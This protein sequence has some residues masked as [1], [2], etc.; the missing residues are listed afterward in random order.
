MPTADPTPEAL[1]EAR[2]IIRRVARS[3]LGDAGQTRR[4]IAAAIRALP[5][6]QR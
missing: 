3:E 1:A 4:D 6:G 5:G 2:D